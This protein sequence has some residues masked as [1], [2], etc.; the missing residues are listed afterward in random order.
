MSNLNKQLYEFIIENASHLTDT[1]IST[2]KTSH[3]NVYSS[4]MP[5]FVEDKLRVQNNKLIH[6]VAKTF[7]L[8]DM[9]LKLDPINEWANEVSKD[10]VEENTMLTD[11][12]E[13]F[14]LFRKIFW[15]KLYEFFV[16]SDLNIAKEDILNWT[17]EFHF[18]FD[19]VIEEFV[20]IYTQEYIRNLTAQQELVTEL[21][22]PIITLTN[23]ISILPIIGTIDT[24]RAKH[25]LESTLLQC[26]E[27]QVQYLVMDLSGVHIVDTMVANQIFIVV[28]ALEVIG[29]KSIVTGIRPEVA[30]TTVQLGIDFSK[31]PTFGTLQAALAQLNFNIVQS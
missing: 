26:H 14:K 8:I 9:N 23:K 2:K 20:K 24:Q 15:S 10:R 30:Q 12:I 31:I 13:Q 18:V 11:V 17:N 28:S 22:S 29:V 21:S 5:K 27:R 6:T 16:R 4:N 25:I 19:T 1:W 3:Q 7:L